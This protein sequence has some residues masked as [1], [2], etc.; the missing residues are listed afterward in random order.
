MERDWL[1]VPFDEKDWAKECGANWDWAEKR[2]YAPEANMPALDRWR[3]KPDVPNVLTGED[4]TFGS[5]LFVDLVPQSAW[6]TNVRSCVSE[7]DW[8]RIRRMVTSRAGNRCEICGAVRDTKAKIWMESHERW[9]YDEANRVQILRRLICLCTP[10]HTAT[11][12][13]L[14]G[15]RGIA[16]EAV[17]HLRRINQWNETQAEAHVREAFDTWERRSQKEWSLDVSMIEG[18]GVLLAKQP[19]PL[20]RKTYADNRPRELTTEEVVDG[21]IA[22]Q[23]ISIQEAK[24][25]LL[26]PLYR[27]R[28]RGKPPESR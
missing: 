26:S 24:R 14:A 27:A 22:G 18:I 20:E 17:E 6:F 13:G 11:H 28:W 15:I 21:E 16:D 4:R 3:A 8:D 7:L 10:C 9:E 19:D 12:M 23:V 2:W 5:G 25:Q 1:D